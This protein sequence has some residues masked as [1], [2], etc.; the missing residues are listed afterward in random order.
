VPDRNP[1]QVVQMQ[2]DDSS[3]P[4]L[5]KYMSALIRQYDQKTPWQYYK[6]VNIQ[7]STSTD[8]ISKIPPPSS[9]PLPYGKPPNNTV[10]NAVLETFVQKDGTSCLGC[11]RGAAIA[12][13][14]PNTPNYSTAYS[15]TFSAAQTAPTG[16]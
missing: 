1:G 9:T 15:F 4:D 12:P 6:I 5:N 13:S 8:D 3:T 10:V 7:W 16:Q 2:K 11:H 14:I